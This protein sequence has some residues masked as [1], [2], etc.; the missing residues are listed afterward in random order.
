MSM[1]KAATTAFWLFSGLGIAILPYVYNGVF[2]ERGHEILD[3]ILLCVLMVIVLYIAIPLI[4][5]KRAGTGKRVGLP[6]KM[7]VPLPRFNRYDIAFAVFVLCYIQSIFHAASILLAIVSAIDTLALI[8]PYLFFRSRIQTGLASSW[9]VFG[10]ALTSIGVNAIGM[11]NGW[12]QFRFLAA[13]DV[14]QGIRVASVFQYHNAFAVFTAAIS[15]GLLTYSCLAERHSVLL[16]GFCVGIASLN[17]VGLMLSGSRGALA[18]WF[19]VLLF[20]LI[21][22]R[23]DSGKHRVR[24][25]FLAYFYISLPGAGFGYVFIH[26]GI[27]HA[28]ASSGWIG[29]IAAILVPLALIFVID[30]LTQKYEQKLSTLPYAF[31]AMIGIGI[32]GAIFV[33]L[34]KAHTLIEKLSSYQIHQLSVVQ[35]FIFWKDGL[36]IVQLNPLFGSGGGAWQAMFMKVESYPYYSTRVH[37]FFIDVLMEVGIIGLGALL[38]SM[39]PMVKSFI[40]PSPLRVGMGTAISPVSSSSLGSPKSPNGK[41][42][43]ALDTAGRRALM[44]IGFMIFIH[45]LMDWDMSFLTL[46]MLFVIGVA[47]GITL[48]GADN[49]DEESKAQEKANPRKSL[50]FGVTVPLFG[51]LGAIGIFTSVQAL[52]AENL[53]TEANASPPGAAQNTLYEQ[54]HTVNPYNPLYLSEL[55]VAIIQQSNVP[56]SAQETR[57]QANENALQLFKQAV[58]LDP[59]NSR[60]Q[61]DGA[62]L[63]FDVGQNDVA[64]EM[65]TTAFYD[66][67]FLQKYISLALNANALY[68]LQNSTSNPAISQQAFTR[69]QS[70]YA[71]YQHNLAIV[72]SLPAYL[73]PLDAYQLE[74]FAYD[75]VAASYLGTRNP[76]T[77]T[78]I[79]SKA[80]SS[81]DTH[82]AETAQLIQLICQHKLNQ[83]TTLE[84]INQFINSHPSVMKS[85]VYLMELQ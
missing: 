78:A 63:A 71:D 23:D 22:L 45:A 75:S 21:G 52:R 85:A 67:P 73:P 57:I 41:Q 9:V 38:F 2:F 15:L 31:L 37:S 34:L 20:G 53:S 81:H 24:I 7:N 29:M 14:T 26:K 32:V 13:I 64:S 69:V 8:V 43:Q 35:R 36:K 11:A 51:I 55:A 66:A 39:W 62:Q 44:G 28:N 40:W 42:G 33:G 1:K 61:G 25:R 17:I 27:A 79:A 50:V 48:H 70:L 16:R 58:K 12:G 19:V 74:D 72:R 18:L 30:R 56:G 6:V 77:A 10:L 46:E 80:I 68:G 76:Q 49:S 54:A 4:V 5:R 47:S 65:A 60:I 82:T 59:F 3:V 84:Q 83:G